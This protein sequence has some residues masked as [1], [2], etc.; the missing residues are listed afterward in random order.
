MA[1]NAL[2]TSGHK[3]T[4]DHF[5]SA[6]QNLHDFGGDDWPAKFKTHSVPISPK[7]FFDKEDETVG[8]NMLDMARRKMCNRL[9]GIAMS[10]FVYSRVGWDFQDSM[11]TFRKPIAVGSTSLV[12]V[13]AGET[14]TIWRIV[15]ETLPSLWDALG[16][17]RTPREVLIHRR[18]SGLPSDNENIIKLYKYRRFP[19][20]RKHRLYME[21]ASHGDL[22]TLIRRY[23]RWRRYFPE[24]FLWY[25]FHHLAKAL[26]ILQ[27]GHLE[28]S[29]D[30]APP[31]AGFPVRRL[32]QVSTLTSQ[33]SQP[34]PAQ[35]QTI[36]AQQA[37]ADLQQSGTWGIVEIRRRCKLLG[38][39]GKGT[40]N[41]K[42]RVL[43]KL[44]DEYQRIIAGV[45]TTAGGSGAAGG[46]PST[47]GGGPSTTGGGPSTTGGGSNTTGD[48][49]QFPDNPRTIEDELSWAR[50][51][52]ATLKRRI[53]VSGWH[54]IVVLCDPDPK[55]PWEFYPI[56]KLADFGDAIET[57]PDDNGNPDNYQY[58]TTDG[59][60]WAPPEAAA[61]SGMRFSGKSNVYQLG[62]TMAYAAYLDPDSVQNARLGN[63]SSDYPY[64]N[65]LARTI[66]SCLHRDPEERITPLALYRLTRA[67]LADCTQ[68]LTERAPD[69][70]R[71][72]EPTEAR[73]QEMATGFYR[74]TPQPLALVDTQF[75]LA[76]VEPDAQ[77]MYLR[78]PTI[79]RFYPY[80]DENLDFF[81]DG[82][83]GFLQRQQ[84]A[85]EVLPQDVISIADRGE[86]YFNKLLDPDFDAETFDDRD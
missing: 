43:K 28:S 75:P 50:N 11:L 39:T 32:L 12:A 84:P 34:A 15:K 64:R 62:L 55:S 65:M 85:D 30:D 78:P 40:H 73:T 54:E 48:A 59:I 44:R 5:G 61:K 3:R 47:T 81:E 7:V 19:D 45:N 67:C 57:G 26:L 17:D 41:K 13:A 53:N 58:E 56:P 24:P 76:D 23:A 70:F 68:Y 20:Q 80:E 46:G 21:Y 1:A 9:W 2:A 27:Q 14:P 52:I 38:V 74:P 77:G 8:K 4:A 18:L 69:R 82:D 83:N 33:P 86:H 49:A 66:E 63:L 22:E 79:D 60:D 10:H 51:A 31:Q 6:R 71:V 42:D 29:E 35:V 37:A 16:G 72:F 36:T 25:I